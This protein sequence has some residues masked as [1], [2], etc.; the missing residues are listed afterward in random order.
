LFQHEHGPNLRFLRNIKEHWPNPSKCIFTLIRDVEKSSK[1][2]LVTHKSLIRRRREG[3]Q[4]ALSFVWL[5]S[6]ALLFAYFEM[7]SPQ[8]ETGTEVTPSGSA[9]WRP[10]WM[11]ETSWSV[12]PPAEK[13]K[14]ANCTLKTT[15]PTL[16]GLI[17]PPALVAPWAHFV[18]AKSSYFV[19]FAS[20]GLIFV[21]ELVTIVIVTHCTLYCASK[22]RISLPWAAKFMSRA[23]LKAPKSLFFLY[24][25]NF[26]LLITMLST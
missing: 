2:Y 6:G 1:V 5:A 9:R 13:E 16:I 22:I 8:P 18:L 21:L 25:E 19:V 11:D 24:F 12:L 7:A 14:C 15:V 20:P 26:R 23:R 4:S 17:V 3:G 10:F